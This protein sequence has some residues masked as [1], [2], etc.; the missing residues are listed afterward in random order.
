MKTVIWFD[1]TW[2][3]WKGIISTSADQMIMIDFLL[4]SN[5]N[6]SIHHYCIISSYIDYCKIEKPT[7]KPRKPVTRTRI[8]YFD[9]NEVRLV[10]LYLILSR[11][12]SCMNNELLILSNNLIS[13]PASPVTSAMLLLNDTNITRYGNRVGHQYA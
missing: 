8:G 11:L 5:F 13:F 6:L 7:V 4:I 3:L 12:A 10:R 1:R 9:I 2:R